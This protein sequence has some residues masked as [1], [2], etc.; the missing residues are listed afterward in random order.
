[1]NVSIDFL[2]LLLMKMYVVV[3]GVLF[4]LFLNKLGKVVNGIFKI[5]LEFN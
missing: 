3:F 1:M 4:V 2:L 5:M